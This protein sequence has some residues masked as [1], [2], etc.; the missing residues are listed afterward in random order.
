MNSTYVLGDARYRNYLDRLAAAGSFALGAGIGGS[1]TATAV[2]LF[3]AL[4]SPL[5]YARP[6]V[7]LTIGTLAVLVQIFRGAISLP[8]VR[9]QIPQ[10]VFA[11]GRNLGLL[12]FGAEYG[13]GV[14]TYLTSS[15]PFVAMGAVLLA[16]PSLLTCLILGALFGIG[17]GLAGI[18]QSLVYPGRMGA[19]FGK[20]KRSWEVLSVVGVIGFAALGVLARAGG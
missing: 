5:P 7:G 13:S 20:P 15:A 4:A 12:Q 10:S 8:Q 11:D 3:G 9:R 2:Y 17:K 19:A 14:R 16:E 1:S 6:A 18:V